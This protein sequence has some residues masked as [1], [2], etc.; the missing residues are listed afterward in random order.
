MPVKVP[1][2]FFFFQEP[3]FADDARNN[4]TTLLFFCVLKSVNFCPLIII[5]QGEN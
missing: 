4:K 2:D 5:P 3:F 1:L